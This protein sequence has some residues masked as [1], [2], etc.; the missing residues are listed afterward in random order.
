M[1]VYHLN[2]TPVNHQSRRGENKRK[3]PTPSVVSFVI[4]GEMRVFLKNLD[5]HVCPIDLEPSDD[6]LTV[7]R[8]IEEQVGIDRWAQRLITTTGK[9]LDEEGLTVSDFNIQEG[10]TIRIIHRGPLERLSK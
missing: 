1:K 5:D 4:L 6:F 3:K 2:V 7:K 8:K 10:A 9:R